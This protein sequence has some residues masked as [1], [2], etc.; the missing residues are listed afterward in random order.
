METNNQIEI[1]TSNGILLIE[2][3]DYIVE[4]CNIT[5]IN[6]DLFKEQKQIYVTVKYDGYADYSKMYNK[7]EYN[8][9]VQNR[10]ELYNKLKRLGRKL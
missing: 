9:R 7:S 3:K 8:K 2:G 6:P 10:Q 5:P 4:G 1:R